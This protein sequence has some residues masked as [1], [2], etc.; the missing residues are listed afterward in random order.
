MQKCTLY[1]YADDNSLMNIASTVN[2]VISNLRSDCINANNSFHENG[3]SSNLAKFQCMISSNLE[4][5][6]VYFEIEPNTKIQF[7]NNV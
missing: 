1:N 2:A 4:L 5:G 6:P 3:M 7:E